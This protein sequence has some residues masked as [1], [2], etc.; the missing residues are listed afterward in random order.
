MSEKYTNPFDESKH[1]F[2]VLINSHNQYSL[3]PEF[4][5]IPAGWQA[6]LGPRSKQEC[7][8]YIEAQWLDIRA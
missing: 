1:Q 6:I 8:N 4:K 5:A 2:V 7:C 3:W